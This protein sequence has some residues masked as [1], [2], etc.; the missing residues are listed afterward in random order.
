MGIGKDVE[1]LVA[2]LKAVTAFSWRECDKSIRIAVST[3]R[4]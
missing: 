3:L 2:Y 1:V 4:I